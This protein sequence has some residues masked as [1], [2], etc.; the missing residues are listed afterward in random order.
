LTEPEKQLTNF[1]LIPST[2]CRVQH[3]DRWLID[4]VRD[5]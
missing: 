5:Y 1:T 4:Y 2:K 3:V